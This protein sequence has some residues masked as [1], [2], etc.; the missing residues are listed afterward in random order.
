MSSEWV[1]NKQTNAQA[2]V[3]SRSKYSATRRVSM[4]SRTVMHMTAERL[5]ALQHVSL[6]P[7]SACLCF[8]LDA[9]CADLWVLSLI[10]S[11][12]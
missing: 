4:Q 10:L 11:E 1:T 9:G 12:N 8:L 6:N 2:L 5:A 7:Y 3:G